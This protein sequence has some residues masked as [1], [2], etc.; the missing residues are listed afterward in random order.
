[1]LKTFVE[2]AESAGV[3]R[4]VRRDDRGLGTA[5]SPSFDRVTPGVK[6][7]RAGLGEK[8]DGGCNCAPPTWTSPGPRHHH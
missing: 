8:R 1:M 5:D 6:P 4:A 2:E 3:D 7:L